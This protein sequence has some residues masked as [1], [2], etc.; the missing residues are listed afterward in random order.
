MTAANRIAIRLSVQKCT[1][2]NKN[3]QERIQRWPVGSA[4]RDPKPDTSHEDG[5]S[6]PRAEA[7]SLCTSRR[8]REGF[9]ILF[10]HNNGGWHVALA[11]T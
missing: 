4:C 11:K 1:E 7:A 6:V 3:C 8:N 2:R 5:L 10:C 9:P